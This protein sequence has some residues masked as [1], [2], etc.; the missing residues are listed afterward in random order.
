[1]KHLIAPALLACALLAVSHVSYTQEAVQESGQMSLDDIATR[2]KLT[3]DQT[4][5]IRP[6]AEQ[7]RARL[8]EIQTR[9]GS[10][11]SRRDKLAL[12]KE[13]RRAQDEFVAQVE[14]L[15]TTEQQS[16]WKQMRA[17]AREEMK[18]RFRKRRPQ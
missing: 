15:L 18:E 4:E 16:Q 10:A 6:Y 8:S 11:N 3:P 5:Q 2:L 7:R 12:M 14:P 17:Q 9:M 1:M 13:G